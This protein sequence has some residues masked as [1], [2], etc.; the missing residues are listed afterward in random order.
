M[1]SSYTILMRTSCRSNKRHFVHDTIDSL[2]TSGAKESGL[3]DAVYLFNTDQNEEHLAY[4]RDKHNDCVIVV[5]DTPLNSIENVIQTL[6]FANYVSSTYIVFC[7]DDISFAK[8]WLSYLDQWC[9]NYFARGDMIVSLYSAYPQ[10]TQAYQESEP[11]WEYPPGSFYGTQGFLVLKEDAVCI[12]TIL[13]EYY[14]HPALFSWENERFSSLD[15]NKL[16]SLSVRGFDMWLPD[17]WRVIKGDAARVVAIAPSLIQHTGID[18]GSECP[19]HK[20]PSFVR[21]VP[22]IVGTRPDYT[23][24]ILT[25]D[26]TKIRAETRDI[27]GTIE[28]KLPKFGY[29]THDESTYVDI[30]GSVDEDKLTDLYDSGPYV[31]A[32][33]EMLMVSSLSNRS[34]HLFEFIRSADHTDTV[35]EYGCGSST[36]GIACAQREA[37]VHIYDIS[38]TMLQYAIERYFK[39]SLTVTVY[40]DTS[41]LPVSA[42]SKVI[43]TDVL[44]HTTDPVSVIKLIHTVMKTGGTAYIDVTLF[45]D[46][47][48]GH[49]PQAIDSWTTFSKEGL[50][51]L[52]EPVSE[53]VYRKR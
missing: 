53:N 18:T 12:A 39:R 11:F 14:L 37:D 52:F 44:E 3:L 20:S 28:L 26:S 34:K 27:V 40:Y 4:I 13:K 23:S 9:N 1:S 51:T 38:S 33:I 10:V 32:Y 8:G 43:C 42:F 48:R 19:F 31:P 21:S 49:L 17:I 24:D 5:P 47:K 29:I 6:Q 41:A 16:S 30:D 46:L 50:L 36:H 22:D 35:L 2:S 45:A 25:L 7:E 15:P